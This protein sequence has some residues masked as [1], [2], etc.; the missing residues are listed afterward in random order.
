MDFTIEG[1]NLML[2]ALS[3]MTAALYTGA[4][5]VND[6]VTGGEPGEEYARQP[7]SFQ[8]AANGQRLI[9]DA[10]LP[11]FNIP[12]STGVTHGAIFIGTARIAEGPVVNEQFNASGTYRL[13]AETLLRL[14]DI[15]EVTP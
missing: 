7:V 10:A 3:G 12:A 13:S 11:L 15:S 1:K 8:P 14:L 4:D 2:A 5:Y 9:D 6:E